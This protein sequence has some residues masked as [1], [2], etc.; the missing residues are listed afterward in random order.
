MFNAI[1]SQKEIE[2]I[3][4]I[5]ELVFQ[6][7]DFIALKEDGGCGYYLSENEDDFFDINDFREILFAN[8]ISNIR[9]A[10][11]LTKIVLIP[12]D[13]DYVIKI[14][15]TKTGAH[16]YYENKKGN[17]VKGKLI[18]DNNNL[19]DY[20]SIE[21]K[22]FNSF[23]D[24]IKKIF[25]ETRFITKVNDLPIYIQEKVTV[26]YCKKI[27]QFD[28]NHYP[29]DR[30]SD[31]D[32]HYELNAISKYCEYNEFQEDYCYDILVNYGFDFLV[33]LLQTIDYAG[34]SDLHYGNY[35]YKNYKPMIYDYS[36]YGE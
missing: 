28:P 36:G 17:W 4:S 23:E 5:V 18:I 25:A 34:I 20:C 35:G 10:S 22:L 3:K 6:G 2:E 7:A 1:L 19:G 8:E 31:M 26:P 33:K 27:D 15:I 21:E 32:I 9:I 11:G 24:D 30:K 29:S 12:D 16:V 13:K 14:P